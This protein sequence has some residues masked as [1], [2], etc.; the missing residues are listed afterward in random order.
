MNNAAKNNTVDVFNRLFQIENNWQ[1]VLYIHTPF[2][3][4][5]CSYCIYGSKV[6]SS[7]AEME[8]FYNHILPGQIEEYR[9]ALEKVSFSQVY[10]GGGTPTIANAT[11]LEKIYQ[12]IPGFM[13]IPMRTTEISPYTATDEHL[14]LFREYG[15]VYVSMG[16]QTLDKKILEKENRLSVNPEKITY[17]C[18]RL[19]EY[20]MVSNVDLIFFLDKGS[21]T[22]LD[23]TRNDLEEMMKTIRPVSLT[24]YTNYRVP[25]DFERRKATIRLIREMLEKYPEYRCINSLLEESDS[26]ITYDMENS[27]E[28]RLMRTQYDFDFYMLQ[29]VPQIHPYGYNMLALGQYLNFRPRYNYYY[30]LDYIEKYK[31]K[32]CFLRA[33]ELDFGYEETREKLNLPFYDF[34]KNNNFF[35]DEAGKEKFKEISKQ[36]GYPYYEF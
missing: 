22:D 29:K 13:D 8:E 3:L 11:T 16:V 17:L 25:K 7:P 23:I 21:L 26:E 10:F 36:A 1:N 9:P 15:F 34:R 28:Y 5:K 14:D 12:Q 33:R 18:R 4:R 20:N 30:I 32:D 19:D 6:P 24:L 2:C 27:V 31:W 35:C